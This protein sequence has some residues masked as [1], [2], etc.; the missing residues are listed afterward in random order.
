MNPF[1][2]SLLQ[3]LDD[4]KLRQ[5]V[6]AWDQLE[7]LIIQVYKSGEALPADETA[8]ERTCY[9]L[10]RHYPRWQPD[11]SRYWP[12]VRAGGEPLE[13]DPYEILLSIKKAGEIPGNWRAMQI[14]PA[15]R[16]ALNQYL[17]DRIGK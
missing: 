9:W 5:F 11:L 7:V 2:R 10:S 15:A 1:T 12:K 6:E 4:R 8:Y 17:L 13:G 16:E 14:L 3:K